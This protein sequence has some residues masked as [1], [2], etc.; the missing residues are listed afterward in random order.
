[1]LLLMKV[2]RTGCLKGMVDGTAR[3]PKMVLKID[4]YVIETWTV[5]ITLTRFIHFLYTLSPDTQL[6]V[7]LYSGQYVWWGGGMHTL[8]DE[9][10][11]VFCIV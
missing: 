8:W 11:V 6:L 3:K 2:F 7:E 4:I 5:I 10:R 9:T 1:M